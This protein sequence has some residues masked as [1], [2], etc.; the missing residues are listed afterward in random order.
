MNRKVIKKLICC[1]LC[2]CMG[3]FMLVGCG[4]EKTSET[5]GE[6]SEVAEK[7][8]DKVLKIASGAELNT[9]YPLNMDIQNY[10][11]DKQV[12][13][14]LVNYVDGKVAPGLAESWEFNDD[15]TKLTFHLKKGVKFHDG[16]EFNAEAVKANYDFARTNPN[17]GNIKALANAKSIDVIDE[18]TVVFTYSSPYFAYLM[19]FCY[20]DVMPIVSPKIIEQGNYQTMKGSVGT[21]PYVYSEFKNGEYTKLEKNK[22]YW[23]E[24]PYYDEILIKYIPEAS[25]RLQALKKGEIDM[26]YGNALVDWDS[27]KQ[28]TEIKNIKGLVAENPSKTNNLVLNASSANLSDIKVREAVAYAI[29]KKALS[30]GLTYGNEPVAEKLF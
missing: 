13:E 29:D 20:P 21:G 5:S 17:F 2:A 4:N 25:S 27:Y 28:A 9:L 1:T 23:G 18:N 11:G 15:G 30:E 3:A 26:I 14:T 12:Y 6:K 19:D 10:L 24:K 8:E 22:N 16:S 7:A